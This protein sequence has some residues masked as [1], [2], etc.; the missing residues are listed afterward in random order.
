MII[1]V[2]YNEM[3]PHN[4]RTICSQ[5]RW[6][7][8]PEK[9]VHHL[10]PPSPCCWPVR[11]RRCRQAWG[12]GT[13]PA[14]PRRCWSAP[15]GRILPSAPS[16][17]PAGRDELQTGV[18]RLHSGYSDINCSVW[19]REKELHNYWPNTTSEEMWA[20]LNMSELS[21]APHCLPQSFFIIW[22]RR[23][24]VILLQLTVQYYSQPTHPTS[25]VQWCCT[26]HS[27]YSSVSSLM[28]LLT[29]ALII[30]TSKNEHQQPDKINSADIQHT[31]LPYYCR[32]FSMLHDWGSTING[33]EI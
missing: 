2:I 10:P 29:N 26:V 21:R 24:A 32:M 18:R 16:S 7:N 14:P 20:V 1:V 11:R 23:A 28:S 12:S 31:T 19:V 22:S 27:P 6:R 9:N 5:C 8:K 30:I 4:C 25:G 15:L 33:T 3:S 13:S 17:A